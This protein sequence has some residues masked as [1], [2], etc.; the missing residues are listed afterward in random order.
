[1]WIAHDVAIPIDGELCALECRPPSAGD[2]LILNSARTFR[3]A[4]AYPFPRRL[5][6]RSL[7]HLQVS[8]RV[9][10]RVDTPRIFDAGEGE[11]RCRVARR[12]QPLVRR[13]RGGGGETMGQYVVSCL[14]ERD[15]RSRRLGRLEEIEH[16]IDPSPIDRATLALYA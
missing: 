2:E 11:G 15:L 8:E 12:R 6:H 7:T 13:S 1:M 5:D 9:V 3:L 14:Q 4:S 16:L 10:I